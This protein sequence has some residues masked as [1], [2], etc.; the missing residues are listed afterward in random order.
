MA[1]LATLR[2]RLGTLD[3]RS[4]RPAEKTADPYY[5][6]AEH[7]EWRRIVL[8]SAGWRC[9]WVTDGKRCDASVANGHRMFADHVNERQ[10]RGHDQ[11]QGMC[12]CG[13]HHTKKTM[14]ERARRAREL[15]G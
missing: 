12:L 4:V 2:P 15:Q 13:A 7:K 11:G 6:T 14:R 8:N 5:H 10:D 1:R 3:T 9:E